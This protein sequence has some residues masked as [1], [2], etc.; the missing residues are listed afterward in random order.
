MADDLG[1]T[2]LSFMGSNY[3]QTPNIDRLAKSGITFYNAYASATNCSPS[4]AS[5]LSG[6]YTTEHGI[7]T[8]GDSERGNKK[9]R[10]LIPIENK[11]EIGQDFFLIPEM[12]KTLGYTNGHFG[13]WHLGKEGHY[14]E[15]NGFDVNFGG[16]ENGGP[17]KGGYTSPYNN[18]KIKNG[19]IGRIFNRSYWKRS[20]KF[21]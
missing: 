15:Q 17:G 2:D 8:V 21:Y 18:P 12:L 5:M 9:T 4:R 7:F 19:P 16:C 6:K 1:W 14:P 20:C 10:K 11:E 3:Y 13:K